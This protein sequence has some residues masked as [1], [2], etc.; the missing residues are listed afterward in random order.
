MERFGIAVLVGL[1]VLAA[2]AWASFV[3]SALWSWYVVPLGLPA[4]T[5]AHALGL[6]LLVSVLRGGSV[7]DTG[8][9]PET[10]AYALGIPGFALLVGWLARGFI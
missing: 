1:G 6:G 5:P 3:V 9:W 4:V 2:V 7:R 10:F 8:E